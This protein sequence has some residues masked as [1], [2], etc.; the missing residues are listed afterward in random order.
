[1][2]NKKT[3][4]FISLILLMSIGLALF[5]NFFEYSKEYLDYQLG[6]NNVEKD[7]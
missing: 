3:L 2:K 4:L 7:D 1:M 6:R 5:S